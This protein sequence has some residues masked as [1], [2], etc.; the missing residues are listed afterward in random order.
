LKGA[1]DGEWSLRISDYRIIYF[2]DE[3]ENIWLETI[4]HRKDFYKKTR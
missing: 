3:Q 1:L 2:C 4:R